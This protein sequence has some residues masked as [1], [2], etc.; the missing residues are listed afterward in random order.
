MA[1][2]Y[3]DFFLDEEPP[4]VQPSAETPEE[5]T[6]EKPVNETVAAP[7]NDVPA[8]TAEPVAE[9]T[10]SAKEALRLTPGSPDFVEQAPQPPAPA[11]QSPYKTIDQ[12]RAEYD[13]SYNPLFALMQQQNPVLD[14]KRQQRLQRIA[15]VNSIGK[16][17]GTILQGYYGKKGA[18]ITPDKNEL[19]P[20]AYKEYI[21][22][23][24]DYK[25]KK[26]L[27]NKDMLALSLKKEDAI[28]RAGELE[29][30]Y[31]RADELAQKQ[32]DRAAQI[33][34]AEQDF[35][36][37]EA[38]LDREFKAEIS[39]TADA[40]ALARISAEYANRRA[41]QR[42]AHEQ[43]LDEIEKYQ[44]AGRWKPKSGSGSGVITRPEGTEDNPFYFRSNGKQV[45]LDADQLDIVSEIIS[46]EAG[47]FSDTNSIMFQNY[48][49][50]IS[51]DGKITEA[52]AR[53]I[54]SRYAHKYY[55]FVDG[56]AVPKGTA[57]A[58]PSQTVST[59]GAY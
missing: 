42:E 57:S 12:I 30:N 28:S 18:T 20:E 34:K 26:D 3:S 19:L 39:K 52:E 44:E 36:A 58:A 9:M 43:R 4:K 59:G 48:L 38:Q 27:W 47:N 29:R 55:D 46:K 33:A 53:T 54:L 37:N 35:R 17:L 21:G 5:I 10:D 49:E 8:V 25:K 1:K 41:M 23:I 16:G 40:N 51:S 50:K 7:V 24:D 31:Q 2:K 32:A 45:F 6:L 22:N 14:E 15:A 13:K 56:K 11:P